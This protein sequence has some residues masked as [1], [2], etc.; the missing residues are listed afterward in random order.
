MFLVSMVLSDKFGAFCVAVTGTRFPN[1]GNGIAASVTI[2]R[3][4]RL[5]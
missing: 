4:E 1:C 2:R 3:A 5:F